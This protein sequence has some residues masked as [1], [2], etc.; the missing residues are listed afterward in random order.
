MFGLFITFLI[1]LSVCVCCSGIDL[2]T[3]IS[4]ESRGLFFTQIKKAD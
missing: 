3:E 2:Y 4:D 1:A